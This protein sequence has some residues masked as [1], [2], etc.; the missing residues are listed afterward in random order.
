[1]LIFENSIPIERNKIKHKTPSTHCG[2][3]FKYYGYQLEALRVID[4]YLIGRNKKKFDTELNSQH[5]HCTQTL[6]PSNR[7]SAENH[8]TT[9]RDSIIELTFPVNSLGDIN[10]KTVLKY[11][12]YQLEALRVIDAYLLGRNKRKFVTEHRKAWRRTK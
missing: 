3:I 6:T 1:M 9:E 2:P 12:G 4:A 11:Y 10:R 7:Q 8:T 5:L